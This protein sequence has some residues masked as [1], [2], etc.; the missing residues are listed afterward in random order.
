[1]KY[2]ITFGYITFTMQKKILLTAVLFGIISIILGAFGAHALKKVLSLEQ[3]N[4]FEVGVRY[5][6]YHAF[7][8][9]FVGNTSMLAL[10]QQKN[11][12]YVTFAGV[13]L[14]SG[15]IFLLSTRVVTN[16]PVSFLGPLTPVGGLFLIVAWGLSFYYLFKRV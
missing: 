13:L 5:L 1:M 7:F 14:F 12:Y 4:S 16:L 6:M 10:H 8:L 11:I 15:S 2:F 9:L 3:L